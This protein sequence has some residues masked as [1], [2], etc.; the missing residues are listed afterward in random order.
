MSFFTSLYFIFF[1]ALTAL[2]LAF[3][4]LREILK[5]LTVDRT[6]REKDRSARHVCDLLSERFPEATVYSNV[7]LL[8]K[9]AAEHGLRCVCDAVYI[10]R[11][12]VLLL[13][14]LPDVGIYDNPKVGPW[15]HRYVNAKKETITL[16]KPNPFDEMAF[17]GTV[18][19]K[20]LLSENVLNPSV[21]RAVVFS[22]NLV[23][24]TT[25]YPECLTI[26]TLFDYVDA[27]NRRVHF[28]RQEYG[29]AAEAISACSDY[30]DSMSDF[31]G[32]EDM[33]FPKATKLP[34]K[35]KPARTGEYT[36][37]S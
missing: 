24:Y 31:S 13:T 9:E 1:L 35:K 27:F 5:I 20:L 29:K 28:N 33:R 15:R 7:R 10:S 3:F 26:A 37:E 32:D 25:N 18:V 16:Q 11:G 2:V 12:G 19:E 6:R 36:E 30:L 8:K 22:A 4:L 17:F 34:P 21:S 23:D 14:V